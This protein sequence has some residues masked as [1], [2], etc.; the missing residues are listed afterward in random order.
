MQAAIQLLLLLLGTV[1][2]FTSTSLLH[3][4]AR[5]LRASICLKWVDGDSDWSQNDVQAFREARGEKAERVQVPSVAS[6][7]AP[8]LK[9]LDVVVAAMSS[10]QRG[11]NEDIEHM[12]RFVDPTGELAVNHENSAG[13]M[14]KFRW[15]VRKEPRW[16]N[17][18]QRPHAALLSMR[19]YEVLGA[20]MTDA[21]CVT[22]RVRA[23][24]YF[25]DAEHAESEVYFNFELVRQRATT[26]SLI[27]MLG[28]RA[29][30]WM[31]HNIAADYASWF[32]KDSIGA[33]RAPD[34]FNPRDFGFGT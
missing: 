10:L 7:P 4:R 14:S 5:P 18:A 34:S 17:I 26:P 27:E 8:D 33:G 15:Q 32:V 28:E 30:C 31:V 24:P 20:L 16:R 2:A 11:G 25:P 21:D 1:A 29:G 3:S 9:P 13:A 12:W 23:S 22:C 6:F 19:S